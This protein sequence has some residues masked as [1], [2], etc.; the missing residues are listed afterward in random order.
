V[1]LKTWTTTQKSYFYGD[2]Q[3]ERMFAESLEDWRVIVAEAP[4]C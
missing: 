4:A 1:F 2:D 3:L